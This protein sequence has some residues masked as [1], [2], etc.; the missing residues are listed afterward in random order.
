VSYAAEHPT[1]WTLELLAEGELLPEE[2]ARVSTHVEQCARCAAEMEAYRAL[3]ATMAELPQFS[4]SPL[5]PEHVM[6]RVT[7]APASGLP[8]WL[9]AW[10][11]KTQ[12]GWLALFGLSVVP[13]LPIV[14]LVWWVITHPNISIGMLWQTGAAWMQDTSWALLVRVLGTAVESNLVA[15]GGVLVDRVM[16]VPLGIL[17]LGALVFAVGI[18]LSAW[19]LYR[20]LRAPSGG[21]T[22]AH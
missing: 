7:I 13:V 5:F 3:F 22:Y 8:A 2:Q 4:P 10:L 9:T 6:E 17:V 21:T 12:R 20:T 16:E 11:P 19:T 1:D 15:W 14:A 18:P